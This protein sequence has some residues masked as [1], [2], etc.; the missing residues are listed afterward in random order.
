MEGLTGLAADLNR[1][2]EYGMAGSKDIMGSSRMVAGIGK[3]H[4]GTG[5][6]DG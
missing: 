5:A 4:T 3:E 2:M 1:P 6:G